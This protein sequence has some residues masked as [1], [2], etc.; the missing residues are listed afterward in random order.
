MHDLQY[1]EIFEIETLNILNKIKVI[2]KLYFGGGTM[3]RLCHNL[4]RFSTVLDFWIEPQTNPTKLF[5]K[6]SDEFS[7]RFKIKDAEEKRN[8][9]LFEIT[10]PNSKRNLVIEIRKYQSDFDWEQKIAFSKFSNLQVAVRGLTL[11]QMMR[12]KTSAFLSR[13]L[14]RDCFDIEFLLFRGVKL[15]L[16]V[17]RLNLMLDIIESFG[18]KDFKVTLGSILEQKDRKFYIENKFQ[19]L[20]EEIKNEI[21]KKNL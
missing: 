21:M 13:K 1:L 20:K 17:E 14:I 18:D 9:L 19:F 11:E 10:S 12:N 8:T 2:D 4:N 15:D 16:D 5:H 3:L 6:I 7:S